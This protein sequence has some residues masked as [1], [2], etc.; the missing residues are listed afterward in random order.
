MNFMLPW[1]VAQDNQDCALLTVPSGVGSD[2][3]APAPSFCAGLTSHCLVG[4]TFELRAAVRVPNSNAY[5]RCSQLRGIYLLSISSISSK[6]DLFNFRSSDLW[7]M[8]VAKMNC[9]ST[10]LSDDSINQKGRKLASIT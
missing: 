10:D 9:S 7:T 3:H 5:L 2:R 1:I 6:V 4:K 8:Q